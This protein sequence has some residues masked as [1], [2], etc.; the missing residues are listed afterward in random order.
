MIMIFEYP[1][2]LINLSE[3]CKLL[4]AFFLKLQCKTCQKIAKTSLF[5]QDSPKNVLWKRVQNAQKGFD[6]HDLCKTFVFHLGICSL[7]IEQDLQ[8]LGGQNGLKKLK[9]RVKLTLQIIQQ[10]EIPSRLSQL[11]LFSK[12]YQKRCIEFLWVNSQLYRRHI[13]EVI[14][15]LHIHSKYGKI[16]TRLTPNTDKFYTVECFQSIWLI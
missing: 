14:V 4:G 7:N 6:A 16:W 1:L 3:S 5:S 12:F 11:I 15:S 10:L 9:N 8:K 13:Y 2:K